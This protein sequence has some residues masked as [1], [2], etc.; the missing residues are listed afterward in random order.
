MGQLKKKIEATQYVVL[1]RRYRPRQFEQVVGQEHVTRTLQNAIAVGRVHHAYLFTGSRGVGKTTVA[2]ILAKALNCENGPT[3]TPCDKCQICID[4]GSSVDI[5]E[6]DGASH[7]GVDDV[8]ELRD[9]VR[10][11]PAH[12]RRKIYIIDEVHMLSTSAFNALLKTLE[13]PP[14]HVIFIFA[15][16]EPHKIP[17]TILSR[18]QRFDFR[19]VSA[20][21]LVE[22]LSGLAK[23]EKVKIDQSGLALIAR[24]AE[25]SVRDSLSLLDQVIAYSGAD[26][27]I[28][29]D[30]VAE[31]LGVADK[32]VHFELSQAVLQRDAKK[33]LDIVSRLFR[34]GQD[35]SQFAQAFLFHLR[36]L[37]VVRSCED[38]GPLVDATKGE[39]EELKKQA[40]GEG[41]ELLQQHFDLFARAA[42]D[43]ARSSFP[44]LVLEMTLVEM[45]HTEPLMPLG[46]LLI[47]LEE[48]ESRL[49]RNPQSSSSGGSGGKMRGAKS[50]ASK[51]S[52]HPGGT[53]STRFSKSDLG[54]EQIT[55][56]ETRKE[57]IANESSDPNRQLDKWQA[58]LK[59][60][61][62]VQ[63]VA[64][65][66]YIGGRLLSWQQDTVELGFPSG[67]F[68][69]QRAS[70]PQK[71]AV[72]EKECCKQVGS[73]LKVIVRAMNP[74]EENSEVLSKMSIIHFRDQQRAEK[75]KALQDEAK[76]H[77]ISRE[78]VGSFGAAISDI[79]TVA[80]KDQR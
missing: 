51:T 38:P 31:I 8:R 54:S 75:A 46:D 52:Q 25:G 49:D 37:I 20:P 26:S 43:I 11:L 58:L 34:E 57:I 1:A 30:R 10:Y 56:T 47:K 42:E 63:P 79:I 72:F 69:L 61:E 59:E 4:G 71:R 29:E 17:A 77:P 16:T 32:R 68:E 70:H 48:M 24:A 6:I 28:G 5:F 78:L 62:L 7:T 80:D 21:V 36:D 55:S 19:R 3:P 39:L 67:S 22:H 60:V 2:R 40:K 33:S 13:E 9:N 50:E 64:V 53:V 15:T 41:A 35:L 12:A 44:R 23:K 74:E 66:A 27:K 73:S 18:C 65:S 45:V 14:P 76:T